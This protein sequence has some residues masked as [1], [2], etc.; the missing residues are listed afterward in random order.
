M[1]ELITVLIYLSIYVG[2]VAT[3]FYILSFL[4]YK[5]KERKFF[6]EKELP[7]VSVIIPAYNEQNSIAR[8]IKS[9][10][11]T[12]YPKERFEVI[13]I[14]DGSK[15]RTL[16]RAKKFQSK[17]VRVFHKENGG[18]GSAL[19]F[20]IKKAK[21]DIIFTMDADTFVEP[22][23]VK[24]MVQ[25]F[26]DPKVMAVTPAILVH[27]PKGIWQR[28]QYMEYYLGIFLR[29]AFAT[30]GS[31]YVTPG[32]FSAYRKKFFDK[33]GGYD[34]KNITEDLEIALRIQY[35]GYLIENSEEAPAY[36]LVPNKF[37]P[38][39]IQRRRWYVGQ[40]KNM[41]SYRKLINRK[42]GDLGVFIIPIGVVSIFFAVF[43]F[44]YSF[45][46]T[47][48]NAINEFVFLA[49]SGFDIS[50]SFIDINFF[51]L[52]R[53]FFLL[54]TNSI[55]LFVIFFMVLSGFYLL[56]TRKRVRKSYGLVINLYLFFLFF[57]ALFSFWWIVSIF[58]TIFTKNIKW[59]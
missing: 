32:A 25:Y 35:H 18:K 21:G 56:W 5:K 51:V 31:V 58:Y 49:N 38:L 53:W 59:R 19:N 41:W 40:I 52:E 20:G 12:D 9:I 54:A 7:S 23:N 15:D 28:I 4:A 27:K 2:V 57:A 47:L 10:I 1:V 11:K 34:E 26:I 48:F 24:K 44:I 22:E 55:F 30:M 46:K 29:K 39:L 8:T 50:L 45:F 37:K 36:T 6:S 33:Y 17:R 42:Y 16:Q 3:T 14:D 13:L 43:I